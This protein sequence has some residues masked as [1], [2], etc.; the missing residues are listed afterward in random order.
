M[1]LSPGSIQST[2]SS[3][4]VSS[5]SNLPQS[6]LPASITLTMNGGSDLSLLKPSVSSTPS[7]SLLL[8][9]LASPILSKTLANDMLDYGTPIKKAH[10]SLP[11]SSPPSSSF[12]TYSRCL[13]SKTPPV[14][15]S[16]PTT[17]TVTT[18]TTTTT[19]TKIECPSFCVPESPLSS[20]LSSAFQFSPGIMPPPPAPPPLYHS[21]HPQKHQL[22]NSIHHPLSHLAL[23]ALAAVQVNMINDDGNRNQ[24]SP[25]YNNH[26]NVSTGTMNSPQPHLCCSSSLVC[27]I[28]AELI[29]NNWL[30]VIREVGV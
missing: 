25:V 29:H 6:S 16:V 17:I 8:F 3:S 2:P 18:T 28:N 10:P 20:P 5:V 23:A 27:S 13:S 22:S 4:S 15:L 11:S 30:K 21:Q 19:P 24:Y 1:P 12:Y 7:S 9:P 26:K 14:T